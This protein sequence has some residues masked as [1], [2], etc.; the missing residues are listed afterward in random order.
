MFNDDADNA[1]PIFTDLMRLQFF[2][3]VL[4]GT[5]VFGPRAEPPEL[6][7]LLEQAATQQRAQYQAYG[8][9]Q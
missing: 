7:T 9:N 2:D 4:L 3:N 1:N 5:V 6:T 8:A